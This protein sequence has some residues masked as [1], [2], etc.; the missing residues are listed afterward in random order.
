MISLVLQGVAFWMASSVFRSE[1]VG[2]FFV[3]STVNDDYREI[4]VLKKGRT[5]TMSLS[6]IKNK[7]NEPLKIAPNK[8]GNCIIINIQ[9]LLPY[10][11]AVYHTFYNQL[12]VVAD[13][14]SE[15]EE[16]IL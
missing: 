13:D 16:I 15:D 3:K 4:N 8:I 5:A 7:Y 1:N 2:S 11:P 6:D 10:I 9:T 12:T 14:V